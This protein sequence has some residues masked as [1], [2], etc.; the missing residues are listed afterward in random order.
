MPYARYRAELES[1]VAR[2]SKADVV[3]EPFPHV[4]VREPLDPE[5]CDQLIAEF[6]SLDVISEGRP[7]KSNQRLNY[8]ARRAA[9]DPLLSP[10]WR[11]MVATHVSQGFLDQLLG[12]F[13]ESIRRTYR[14]RGRSVRRSRF[15]LVCATSTPS[16]RRT[17]CWRPNLP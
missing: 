10:L 6:P 15:A 5:L 16:R 8:R 1:L 13:G 3:E 9:D 7:H 11:G 17:S 12:L 2:V 14:S 4:V